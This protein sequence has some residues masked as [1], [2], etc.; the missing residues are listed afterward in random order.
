MAL[1]NVCIEN[2][3]YSSFSYYSSADIH[4]RDYYFSVCSVIKREL[5]SI[6]S[7][8]NLNFCKERVEFENSNPT[9]ALSLQPEH[10]LVKPGGRSCDSSTILGDASY[11]NENYLIRLDNYD[12]L[13]NSDAILDY[14]MANI[15]HLGQGKT[16]SLINNFFHFAPLIYD[17]VF[18][19][20]GD[21]TETITLFNPESSDRRN[22]FLKGAGKISGPV[23]N[24]MGV[25]DKTDLRDIYKKCRILVNIH[26][27]PHHHTLEE[28]RVLPAILNGV[29]VV[30]ENAPL[31]DKIPYSDFIVWS[32]YS[33]ISDT[34]RWVLDDYENIH[35]K[36]F[37]FPL[38]EK[39]DNMRKNNRSS[40]N[41]LLNHLSR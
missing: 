25:F 36:L 24:I 8:I 34:I 11:D 29:I 18:F 10:T 38:K 14:S 28:L 4:I 2:I 21:R 23:K 1:N 22:N 12:I 7:D 15:S 30:S 6:S 40:I 37:S 39:I 26:Q 35:D 32:E 16:K 33:D 9:F 20:I 41:R 5:P 19:D 17:D 3:G 31:K 13:K 27:T